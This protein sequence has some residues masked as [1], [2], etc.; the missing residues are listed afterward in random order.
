[1]A[2]RH[3]GSISASGKKVNGAEFIVTLP[4]I[5]TKNTI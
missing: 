1:M 4:L 2:E 3:G 5:Q